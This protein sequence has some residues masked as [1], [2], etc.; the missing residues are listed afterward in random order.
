MTAGN[1]WGLANFRL[2]LNGHIAILGRAPKSSPKKKQAQR[3]FSS[4][5]PGR[6]CQSQHRRVEMA[7]RLSLA[8]RTALAAIRRVRR[9]CLRRVEPAFRCFL[10]PRPKQRRRHDDQPVVPRLFLFQCANTGHRRLRPHV[11]TK[12]LRPRHQHCRDYDRSVFARSDD[13]FD[14]RPILAADCT[15]RV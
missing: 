2:F 13:W 8:T 6:I 7:R 14:F 4:I 11:S 3:S 12:H 9:G 5:R 1:S 10:Q 15:S